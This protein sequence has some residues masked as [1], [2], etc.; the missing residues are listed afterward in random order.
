MVEVVVV[1]LVVVVICF[2]VGCGFIVDGNKSLLQVAQHSCLSVGDWQ[3]ISS[4]QL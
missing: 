3:Y 4:H 1:V 2:V